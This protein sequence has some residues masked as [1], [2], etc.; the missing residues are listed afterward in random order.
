[1]LTA[2]GDSLYR[3]WIYNNNY[4]DFGLANYLPSVTGTITTLFF[5]CGVSKEFPANIVKSSGYGVIGCALYEILQ[6]VFHTGIFDW[7]DLIAVIVTGITVLLFFKLILKN[8]ECC[9]EN[10]K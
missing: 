5:L 10:K 9:V 3:N 6:P 2:I 1:M 4:F 8:Q 7:Q